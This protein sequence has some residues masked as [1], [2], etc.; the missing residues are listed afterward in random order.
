MLK[1]DWPEL[2]GAAQQ[3]WNQNT[4]FWD[5]YMGDHS[6]HVPQSAGAAGHGTTAGRTAR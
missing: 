1:S 6:K 5:D 3:R 4:A 2:A